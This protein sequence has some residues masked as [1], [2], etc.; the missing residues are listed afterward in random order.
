[1]A[2]TAAKTAQNAKEMV[3]SGNYRYGYGF[4]NEKITQAKIDVFAK[5]YPSVYTSTNKDLMK[6]K[7]GK[8]GIDCSG[9]V[10]KAAGVSMMGSAQIHS[11][12]PKSYKISDLSHLVNGM[13]LYKPGH[14]AIVRIE[15]GKT[16]VDEA[17]ST[18]ND[19]RTTLGTARVKQFTHYGKI[20]GVTYTRTTTSTT[21]STTSYYA[22]STYTGVSLV[23]ALNKSGITS[24]LANRKLIAA[25]N[26]IT[27][28]TGTA[29]QND[30]LLT[31]LKT[32]KLKKA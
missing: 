26:G 25:K 32:G 17:M 20:K 7:I 21:S 6:K 23:D 27:G 31:L 30:K 16:Y 11:S 5:L 3:A 13:Y 10:C 19:L 8:T 22:K 4:K 9:F 29:A 2:N 15:N 1:M 24:T 28:Y 14:I 12:S 18:A